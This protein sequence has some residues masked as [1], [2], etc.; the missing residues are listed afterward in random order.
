MEVL[1]ISG[2]ADDEIGLVVMEEVIVTVTVWFIWS[3]F[4]GELHEQ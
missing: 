2:I 3:P 4:P 1:M